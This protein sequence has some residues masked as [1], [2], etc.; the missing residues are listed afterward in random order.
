[1]YDALWNSWNSAQPFN[2]PNTICQMKHKTMMK[3]TMNDLCKHVY[4]SQSATNID[5]WKSE[6]MNQSISRNDQN[7]IDAMSQDHVVGYYYHSRTTNCVYFASF[8][9]ENISQH[10]MLQILWKRTKQNKPFLIIRKMSIQ[11]FNFVF[12]DAQISFVDVRNYLF[13]FTVELLSRIC[14][15][16]HSRFSAEWTQSQTKWTTVWYAVSLLSAHTVLYSL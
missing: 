7:R 4:F 10:K 13:K 5:K 2:F 1:M 12:F 9:I 15:F 6:S 14:V 16:T 11:F 8:S 3:K